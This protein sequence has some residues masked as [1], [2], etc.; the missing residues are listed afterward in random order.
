MK[1]VLVLIMILAGL[2]MSSCTTTSSANQEHKI[3]NSEIVQ[4]QE[5]QICGAVDDWAQ[6]EV[7]RFQE[8]KK[9]IIDIELGIKYKVEGCK[10]F[11]FSDEGMGLVSFQ[12]TV[13]GK[14]VKEDLMIVGLIEK[15]NEILVPFANVIYSSDNIEVKEKAKKEDAELINM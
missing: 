13:N 5:A 15:N 8:F 7:K 1:N 4:L 12:F 11:V 3:Q 9:K 14:L 2:T 10:R 6:S